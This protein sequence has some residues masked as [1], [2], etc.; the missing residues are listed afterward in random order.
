MG[1]L[2]VESIRS[3]QRDSGKEE[4]RMKKLLSATFMAVILVLVTIGLAAWA[5]TDTATQTFNVDVNSI[6]VIDV[7]AP[8][9]DLAITAPL[10][11]GADPVSASDST[12]Y[13]QYTSTVSSKTR[14]I[15]AEISAGSLPGGTTLNLEATGTPGT[16]E[17]TYVGGGVDLTGVA[18]NIITGIGSCATGTA[19]TDGAQLTYT[20]SI[21]GG[22]VTG[23]V[24]DEG[25]PITVTLTL[26]A[27]AP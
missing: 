25:N 10:T 15:T 17:G 11:G 21:T 2:I 24:A 7:T 26:T 8:P 19:G 5:V 12:T 6:A 27:E 18:G 23:L 13:A 3:C 9:V 4:T 20:L 14:K 1:L 16:N 22:V